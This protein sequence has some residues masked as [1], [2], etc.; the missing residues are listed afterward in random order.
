MEAAPSAAGAAAAAQEPWPWAK[1]EKALEGVDVEEQHPCV[2]LATGTF[3]PVHRGHLEM[4]QLARARLVDAGYAVLGAWLSLATDATAAKKASQLGYV[5]MPGALRLRLASLVVQEDDFLSASSW[6]VGLSG[7]SP[8]VKEVASELQQ[9][10]LARFGDAFATNIGIKVFAVCGIDRK[11]EMKRLSSVANQGL[12]VVPRSADDCI[13]EQP[14]QF[15][16]ASDPPSSPQVGQISMSQLQLAL[17]SDDRSYIRWALPSVAAEFLLGN[18]GASAEFSSVLQRIV[19]TAPS[20]RAGSG[21]EGPWPHG[22]VPKWLEQADDEQGVAVLVASGSMSPAHRGHVSMLWQAKERLER[23]GYAVIG[24]WLS[25]W[26]DYQAASAAGA[27]TPLSAAFRR[28]AAELA[29]CDDDF[30]AVASWEAS[31]VDRAPER[32][33]VMASLK[34]CIEDVFPA[35][36]GLRQVRVFFVGGPDVAGRAVV[37]QGIIANLDMGVVVVPRSSDDVLLEKTTQ[38]IFAADA[39]AEAAPDA[40]GSTEVELTS[41]KIREA[42]RNRQAAVAAAAMPAAAARFVLSPTEAEREE[43]KADFELL[44]VEAPS[45]QEL[46]R[47][48][49]S[50][51]GTLRAWIGP[52]AT[53]QAEEFGRLLQSLDPSWSNTDLTLL[54]DTVKE[55][56]KNSGT[57]TA[58]GGVLPDQF[59]DWI[60]DNSGVVK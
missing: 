34:A 2:I 25:P 39:P 55:K 42:L 17:Q 29:V 33:E 9:A 20:A 30:V 59:V 11:H 14:S 7:E 21:G 49:E 23:A 12:V 51:K 19:G 6:E 31:I 38:L 58:D 24:G 5:E 50:L 8:N 37:Q 44:G 4:V 43:M 57:A 46:E 3:S 45:G 60:F 22:K 54:T 56:N 13:L 36:L 40:E 28:R 48:R 35:S 10:I 41:A 47:A 53:M 26:S 15:M 18:Q 27:C 1:F 32:H 52:S 16:F